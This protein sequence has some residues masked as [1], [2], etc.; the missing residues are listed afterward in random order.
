[1]PAWA[2]SL[3][4]PIYIITRTKWTGRVAK[5]VECLLC[6]HEA[7]SSKSQSTGK[8]NLNSASKRLGKSI[9]GKNRFEIV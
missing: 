2:N 3:R 4:D 8:K 6:K 1:M 7:L 5:A 9:N